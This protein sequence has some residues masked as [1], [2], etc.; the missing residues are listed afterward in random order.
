[1]ILQDYGV[2]GSSSSAQI[3]SSTGPQRSVKYA[4]EKET[5]KGGGRRKRVP[6]KCLPVGIDWHTTYGRFCAEMAKIYLHKP[7]GEAPNPETAY[8]EITKFIKDDLNLSVSNFFYRDR[9]HRLINLFI[10]RQP[11]VAKE[12]GYRPCRDMEQYLAGILNELRPRISGQ[13][14]RIQYT[15]ERG[16][17]TTHLCAR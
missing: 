1:M 14:R 3:A 12:L 4:K 16:K 9:D 17:P 7:T 5:G 15:L 6:Q 10:R 8:A 2:Q 13:K 11:L